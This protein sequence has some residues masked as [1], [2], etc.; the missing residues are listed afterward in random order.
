MVRRFAMISALVLV[1]ALGC[2]KDR[3]VETPTDQGAAPAVAGEALS[4]TDALKIAAEKYPDAPAIEVEM[5]TVDGQELL[6]VEFLVDG[7]IKEL[8]LDPMSGEVVIEKDEELE[9]EEAATL[10]A[11]AEQLG[12]S[13]VLLAD[14]ITLA[15]SKYDAG[16]IREIELEI[17]DGNLVM[18]VEVADGKAWLHDPNTGDVLGEDAEE[19]KEGDEE[20]A[21]EGEPEAEKTE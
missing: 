20:T 11:L 9:P 3:P 16:T 7:V 8:Y 14:V 17:V 15:E 2:S 12:S 1:P 10:P 19:A 5:E 13:G 21:E 18:T 4:F 6:E